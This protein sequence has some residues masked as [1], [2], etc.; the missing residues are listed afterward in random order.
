[1][2]K[3]DRQRIREEIQSWQG[4]ATSDEMLELPDQLEEAIPE[5]ALH[6]GMMCNI[7][8][9]IC[10]N[11]YQ[12]DGA[13][14][15]HWQDVHQWTITGRSRTGRISK[16]EQKR[17]QGRF[18]EAHK[19]VKCQRFFVTRHGSHFIRVE[20]REQSENDEGPTDLWE[21]LQERAHKAYEEK[22]RQSKETIEEGEEDD[23]N[24]WLSRT[25]WHK[26]LQKPNPKDMMAS[27]A[28][29]SADPEGPEPYETV[30]WKAITDVAQISQ[31]TVSKAG[32][33]VRME[34]VRS[35]KHQTRYMPLETYWDPEEIAR[36]VQPW[37]QMMLFFVRTQ[38]E[39]DWQSPSYK[40]TPEQF[41]KFDRMIEE[42][43]RVIDGEVEQGDGETGMSAI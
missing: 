25:K 20:A 35:E 14:R 33:F 42:A 6:D 12:K 41:E 32:V 22:I 3:K 9:N 10:Q 19:K 13:L 24:P 2:A 40:F 23:V 16:D 28:A 34:A 17:A 38:R 18:D 21:S 11:V 26:Y 36:R 7:N 43:G 30:I 1:M 29:P 39:H 37:R 8:P 4:L 27:V 5:L 31:M 15:K